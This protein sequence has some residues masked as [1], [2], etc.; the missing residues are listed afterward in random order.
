[1]SRSGSGAELLH[2]SAVC[3][4]E[5]A[6]LITGPAGAGK[7]TL[8]LEMIALGAGLVADDRVL[9]DRGDDG[10][11]WLAP[12]GRMAGLAEVRGFGMIRLGHRPR[13]V[14]A[15]V[16]DLGRPEPERLPPRR[17][18]VIA[19]IACPLIL[20]EGRPGLAGVLV[21]LLRAEAWLGPEF[22]PGR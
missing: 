20:C 14:L 1:M 22:L 12:P 21:T 11:V 8:A 6:V 15:L 4:A 18:C 7:T 13:S 17:E 9:A 10:R 5:R 16:A 2:A 19:G 3:V